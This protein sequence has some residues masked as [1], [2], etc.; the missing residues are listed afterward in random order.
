M[1]SMVGLRVLVL[2]GPGWNGTNCRTYTLL[3]PDDGLLARPK[4][5]EV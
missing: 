4:H 3:P 5:I 2:D 1:R